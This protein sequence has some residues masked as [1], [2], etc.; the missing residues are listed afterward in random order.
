MVGLAIAIVLCS[1]A[2]GVLGQGAQAGVEGGGQKSGAVWAAVHFGLASLGS[3]AAAVAKPWIF[4]EALVPDQGI[5]AKKLSVGQ[6]I[7]SW[8]VDNMISFGPLVLVT[9]LM[10]VFVLGSTR[11]ARAGRAVRNVDWRA[12]LR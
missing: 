9:G 5:F 10:L 3:L 1:V 11:P 2:I 4:P 12:R 7:I 6:M 8:V